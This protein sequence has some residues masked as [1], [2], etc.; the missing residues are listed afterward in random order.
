MAQT[1]NNKRI[2]RKTNK[3][4]KNITIQANKTRKYI[5]KIL[6]KANKTRKFK[7]GLFGMSSTPTP[8]EITGDIIM[9]V[10]IQGTDGYTRVYIRVLQA[11]ST[12]FTLT[13]EQVAKPFPSLATELNGIFYNEIKTNNN[14]T[15]GLN[16]D[17][18]NQIK[19]HSDIIKYRSKIQGSTFLIS[20]AR[21]AGTASSAPRSSSMT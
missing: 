14:Q 2:I 3:A 18:F 11:A 6:N 20:S 19:G 12:S 13:K 7:A 5:K 16:S 15:T 21:T 1:K 8:T 17:F 4:R 10:T 9:N